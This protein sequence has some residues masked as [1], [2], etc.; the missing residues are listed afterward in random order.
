M[1]TEPVCFGLFSQNGSL[2]VCALGRTFYFYRQ[3]KGKPGAF[4]CHTKAQG[5]SAALQI[6]KLNAKCRKARRKTPAG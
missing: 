5:G 1:Q 4:L 2:H 3:P 6:K